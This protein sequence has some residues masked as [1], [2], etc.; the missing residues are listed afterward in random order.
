MTNEEAKSVLNGMIISKMYEIEI[1]KS[2]QGKK[3][4]NEQYQ[5]LNIAVEVLEKQMPKVAGDFRCHCC[6]THNE[7]I[8]KRK[9]Q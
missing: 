2:K 5:A 7:T 4:L 8:E 9:I 3:V 1:E 6:G